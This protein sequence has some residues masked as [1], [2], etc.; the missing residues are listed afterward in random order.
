MASTAILWPLVLQTALI[1]IVYVLVSIKRK[2]SVAA[3]EAKATDFRVPQTEA[4]RS[5]VAIRNLS[6]QFELPVLFY[7][8]CILFHITS[9]ADIVVVVMAWTFVLSRF[10]HAYV[11]LSSNR[12]RHRRPLFIVGYAA[13]AVLWIWFAIKLAQM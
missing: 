9:G 10:A 3:G 4:E 11:H 13:N 12:I 1:Y 6:N 7:V 2:E 5:A 8:V